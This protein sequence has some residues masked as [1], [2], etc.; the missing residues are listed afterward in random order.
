MSGGN[1]AAVCFRPDFRQIAVFDD[2]PES[3]DNFTVLPLRMILY[4]QEYESHRT[5]F[6]SFETG[7]PEICDCWITAR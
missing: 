6:L 1:L 2:T 4:F 5:S 7:R 3:F